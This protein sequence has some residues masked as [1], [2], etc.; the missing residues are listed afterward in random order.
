M[1]VYYNFGDYI[2]RTLFLA[3][4]KFL[5]N[6][7]H[8]RQ[9]NIGLTGKIDYNKINS[10]FNAIT[11]PNAKI[12]IYNEPQPH[13]G[14]GGL[15][16]SIQMNRVGRIWQFLLNPIIVKQKSKF[17]VPREVSTYTNAN[18]ATFLEVCA[19]PH[20]KKKVYDEK[21]D[22]NKLWEIIEELTKSTID[23]V[24][25]PALRNM[26]MHE[27]ILLG[28]KG[29]NK[30]IKNGF[31]EK[32]FDFDIHLIKNNKY[33]LEFFGQDLCKKINKTIKERKQFILYL[34]NL[35][36]VHNIQLDDYE[37]NDE[38]FYFGTRM[39][40][41]YYIN[42]LFI[43]L[44]F[45]DGVLPKL[46]EGKY[47]NHNEE[48]GNTI[49]Y[50]CADLDYEELLNGGIVANKIDTW[51]E[52][53]NIKYPIF[54]VLLFNLIKRVDSGG[55]KVEKNLKKLKH[56]FYPSRYTCDS[57]NQVLN[58]V[59]PRGLFK[60]KN[61]INISAIESDIEIKEESDIGKIICSV[62][63]SLKDNREAM[64]AKCRL[65]TILSNNGMM[66][67]IFNES[68][69]IEGTLDSFAQIVRD[70][71]K[72]NN[73]RLYT[74]GAY[75][76]INIYLQYKEFGLDVSSTSL[77]SLYKQYNDGI[78]SKDVDNTTIEA[79]TID[80]SNKIKKIN[81]KCRERDCYNKLKDSFYV[82]RM[83]THVLLNDP[84]NVSA[85]DINKLNLVSGVVF[86]MPYF[87]SSTISESGSV[88]GFMQDASCVF[89]IKINKESKKWIIVDK[90]SLVVREREVLI[91]K[92]CVFLITGYEYLP[93]KLIT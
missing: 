17:G 23:A 39:K 63:K 66:I 88:A 86:T 31:L 77:G 57:V 76:P 5:L 54:T 85:F 14:G 28:G 91:D 81:N 10:D 84:L 92:H 89:K 68:V 30:I 32:S 58:N 18:K 53:E 82:Y 15:P 46:D 65:D 55:Y 71:D 37:D 6:V 59:V 67:K 36:K 7:I 26:H 29:L 27:Y 48:D 70:K 11:G 21:K 34:K 47:Y 61:K 2:I 64:K 73:V 83:Q 12:P 13:W 22:I 52:Y 42:S 40:K 93:I 38:L 50:P 3:K 4:Y 90:A 44:K 56:F 79:I 41:K 75:K 9:Y 8:N 49:Y 78:T 80:I 16:T 43:K 33:N 1:P 72:C 87:V 25:Y 62:A 45:R 60:L 24:M 69:D 35:F 74:G 19:L 20:Y 51:T